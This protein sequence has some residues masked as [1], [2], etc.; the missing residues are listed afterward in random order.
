MNDARRFEAVARPEATAELALAGL[1]HDVGKLLQRAASKEQGRKLETERVIFCPLRN[2]GQQPGGRQIRTHQHAA[3]TAE[4][5]ERAANRL[6]LLCSAEHADENILGWASRHHS[7][8][9]PGDAIVAT[10]DR[11]SA[12]MD[13]RGD[14]LDEYD[15]WEQVVCARLS[16]I[17]QRVGRTVP[18]A[19]VPVARLPVARLDP[20]APG[21]F[22]FAETPDFESAQREY[23]TVAE[24][25]E[26]DAAALLTP[27]LDIDGAIETL[28]CLL[29]RWTA[30]VPA[31]SL[32]A[33]GQLNDVSL[34]D[35]LRTAAAIAAVIHGQLLAD[36]VTAETFE[37]WLADVDKSRFALA[38]GDVTGI[39]S[40]LSAL[41]SKGAARGM[42]GRSFSVQLLT[43]S[44]ARAALR[45]AGMPSTNLIYQG[46]GHFWVLLPAQVLVRTVEWAERADFAVHRWSGARLG[47][48]FGGALVAPHDLLSGAISDKWGQARL[49]MQERRLRR[50]SGLA[51]CDYSDIF[52]VAI[53]GGKPSPCDS[54][55][56]DSKGSEP[57]GEHLCNECRKQQD[58]GRKLPH[59]RYLLRAEALRHIDGTAPG[60]DP[61]CV[62]LEFPA[63]VGGAYALLAAVPS[64]L[65]ARCSLLLMDVPG[66]EET[67]HVGPCTQWWVARNRPTGATG[68]GKTYEDLARGSS[69]APNLGVLRADV[70]DLGMIF[71]K[72]LERQATLSRLAALSRSLNLFFAGYVRHKVEENR[73]F[74]DSCQ[75]IF[76]GGD[77]LLVVGAWDRLPALAASIRT[78]L[79][80]YCGGVAA[81][82]L[83]AGIVGDHPGRPLS[84]IAKAAAEAEH[85]AK[86]RH[87]KGRRKNAVNLLGRTLSWD[88]LAVAAAIARDLATLVAPAADGLS[89]LFSGIV[90]ESAGPLDVSHPVPRGV[91]HKL[92]ALAWH[93]HETRLEAEHGHP[94]RTGNAVTFDQIQ[95]SARRDRW[96]WLAAYTLGRAAGRAGENRAAVEE[97]VSSLNTGKYRGLA[98]SDR[99][100]IE[101]LEVA[102]GWAATLTRKTEPMKEVKL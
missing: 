28:L 20:G 16:P 47:F 96:M 38:I 57:L 7:P 34:F 60:V 11:L 74:S 61:T 17:L 32:V 82:T 99:W 8:Y 6:P 50:F 68:D 48:A 39:Q 51:A 84:T 45:V 21:F 100:I 64:K 58:I 87:A 3:F 44:L 46:G 35:H 59:S 53:P 67:L 56:V 101:Y 23:R 92:L 98:G 69:G 71:G 80:R 63:P 72:G 26:R 19:E 37:P 24:G 43:D 29:E 95:T 18:A 81:V 76:S 86:T 62:R 1:L 41:T 22:P 49:A 79:R 89:D 42:R 54:C 36:K 55:G 15:G 14:A 5:I 90:P 33:G 83:S 97:I 70:D 75:I 27:S 102:A 52:G 94:G 12:G 4:F 91:L 85:H 88:E 78:D 73:V 31:S 77:D 40:Y 65:P 93:E 9:S 2:I 66:Q 10:A 13:R 25:F 30:S